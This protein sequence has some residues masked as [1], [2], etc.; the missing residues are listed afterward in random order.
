MDTFDQVIS[1][2]PLFFI[3]LA[4]LLSIRVFP[5]ESPR[6]L[7]MFAQ[8]CIIT[9]LV[10]LTGHLIKGEQNANHWL[11]NIFHIFY[12]VYL[13]SIFYQQLKSERIK[14]LISVFY[15][16]FILFA[17]YNTLFLQ[18]LFS[19]QT[20]PLVIGG[21]FSIF[22]SGAYF[23]ELFISTDHESITRDPFFWFTFGLILYFGG[24]LP[25]LG[26]FNYMSDNFYDFTVFYYRYFSN[27]FSIL[28]N[29]LIMIG[30][31]CRKSYQRLS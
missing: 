30:F 10:E 5:G 6:P 25:F 20:Y 3:G 15:I 26:M 14:L 13:A 4:A 11:Y 23:W 28:L 16:V 12:Y 31:L 19:L 24:T 27:A 2:L 22:L 8:L 1:F 17:I 7:R 29:I 9:F 18:D 21:A